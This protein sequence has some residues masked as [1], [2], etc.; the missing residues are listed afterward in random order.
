MSSHPIAGVTPSEVVTPASAGEVADVLRSTTGTV[1][2]VGAGTKTGWAAPPTS[3]DLLLRTTELNRI[4]EHVPGDLV[5][6]AEAGV[7]LETLQARLAEHNQM[8]A[9]DPP[10]PGATLGGIVG[11]NASGP[12][13]LRYGTVRDLLIGVTVVLADGTTARSGGKV[14]KNVA[15]YDLGKLYTGAHGALG[16]LVSTTWRLHPLPAAAGTV[17]VPVADAAEAG[18][19]ASLLVRSTLTPTAV[20]L[21]WDGG[22]GELVVLF[23]SIPASVDAQSAAAVELLGPGE[24]G[25]EPPPWFGERPTGGVV[26]R[27]AYEPH[28]LPRVLAALPAEASG[29][30][31]A[32]TGVAY[33]AV[34]ADTDL[35]ALRAAIASYDGSA[36][37]LDR[38][39]D[40]DIDHWGPVPDSF[41]LMTRV[42]DQ[43]DPGRRLSPGRLLGGL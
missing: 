18:R 6:V 23:E 9:L 30:A 11:A 16:V 14:V 37:V 26:L 13:R 32:G 29:T 20:E 4:V 22:A 39:A 31:S 36:V 15:G 5:V 21:R 34:P 17:T 40:A 33:M 2:P 12:R 35:A 7:P 38:P 25:T 42:K 24:R 10:E 28:A 41:G 3:C 1:V 43:F 8:L 19:L 27:L